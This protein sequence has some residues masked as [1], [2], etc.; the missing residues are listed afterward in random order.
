M[1]TL[2]LPLIVGLSSGFLLFL[3]ASGLSLVFGLMHVVNFAHGAFAMVGAYVLFQV[4]AGRV[5]TIPMF[6]VAVLV[7]GLAT[8]G[9]GLVAERTIFRRMYEAP[10]I[11]TL[12]A[13]F[14]LLLVLQGLV[15]QVWGVNPK[16][17]LAPASLRGSV[18]MLGTRV[19]VYHLLAIGLGL[20]ALGTL[21]WL[22]YRSQVGLLVRAVAA[23]RDMTAALGV[24][25]HRV[26]LGMFTFGIFL[27]GIAGAF[28]APLIS[29]DPSLGGQ[30]VVNAFAVVIIGGLGSISGTLLAA[31]LIGVISSLVIVHVPSIAGYSIYLALAFV[32][33]VRPQ[34]LLGTGDALDLH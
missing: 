4:L 7:A 9:L 10:P 19:P 6:L 34:G 29:L 14:A 24:R 17:V 26:F 8:A 30:L 16:S 13:S 3:L 20:L 33:L 31:I 18:G 5:G 25:I 23:D 28:Q 11:Q 1:D 27:A 12:L 32:L 2:L 15:T 21:H 22:M